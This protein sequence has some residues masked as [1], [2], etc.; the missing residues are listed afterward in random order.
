MVLRPS[1]VVSNVPS[2]ITMTVIAALINAGPTA[3]RR[4]VTPPGFNAILS[5]VADC[6][7][8]LR[9]ALH[10]RAYCEGMIRVIDSH[11]VRFVLEAS[12]RVEIGNVS[13]TVRRF[14]PSVLLYHISL[15]EVEMPQMFNSEIRFLSAQD[16]IFYRELI[17]QKCLYI[18]FIFRLKNHGR[19]SKISEFHDDK[20]Q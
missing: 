10:V 1:L 19:M 8:S 6:S 5:G 11:N 12:V 17:F 2:N 3:N 18:H 4:P 15:F 13:R 20:F 9:G 7:R 14:V 16:G